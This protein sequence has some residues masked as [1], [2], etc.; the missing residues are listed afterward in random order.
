VD[1]VAGRGGKPS[2]Q[3]VAH[4]ILLP[5]TGAD[6]RSPT[7]LIIAVRDDSRRRG[8][9]RRKA[10]LIGVEKIKLPVA[11]ASIRCSL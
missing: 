11:E 1:V 2:A 6:V 8:K 5:V 7:L 3:L 9:W 10:P 4:K